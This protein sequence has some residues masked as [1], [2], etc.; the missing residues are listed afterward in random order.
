MLVHVFIRLYGGVVRKSHSIFT[1]ELAEWL[2]RI[3]LLA[4]SGLLEVKVVEVK[5]VDVLRSKFRTINVVR[6]EKSSSLI[7]SSNI[8]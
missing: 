8:S 2:V 1:Q 7:N 3:S 4:S 6:T 5:S